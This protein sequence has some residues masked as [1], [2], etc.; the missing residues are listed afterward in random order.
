MHASNPALDTHSL[1]LGFKV[2]NF[3]SHEKYYAITGSIRLIF[4]EFI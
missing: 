1:V 2:L 4:S 3:V